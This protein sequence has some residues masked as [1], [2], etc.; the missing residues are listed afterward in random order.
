MVMDVSKVSL[1]YN[2]TTCFVVRDMAIPV[3]IYRIL[4]GVS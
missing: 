3:Q 4:F 2:K 1:L